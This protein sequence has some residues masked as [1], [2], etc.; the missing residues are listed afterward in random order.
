[1]MFARAEKVK[2]LNLFFPMQQ[3]LFF[4]RKRS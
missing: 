3:L 1:V 4:S 2:F